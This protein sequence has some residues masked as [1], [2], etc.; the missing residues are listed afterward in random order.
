MPTSSSKLMLGF[1]AMVGLTGLS[2]LYVH[3]DQTAE[4]QRM[5]EAVYMDDERLKRKKELKTALGK[6]SVPP[7]PPSSS[8]FPPPPSSS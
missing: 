1:V 4:R 5:R 2:I 3:H 7:P 8:S 6:K